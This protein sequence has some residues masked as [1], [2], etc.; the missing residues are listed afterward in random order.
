MRSKNSQKRLRRYLKSVPNH[1]SEIRLISVPILWCLALWKQSFY[2]GWGIL[3]ATLTDVLD[4]YI[5]RKYHL[6]TKWGSKL[7]SVADAVLDL[8]IFC[9]FILF[10]PEIFLNHPILCGIALLL[11]VSS[12]LYEWIRFKRFANLHLY[13]IKVAAFL[14]DAL[15]VHSFVTGGYSVWLFYPAIAVFIFAQIESIALQS[16]RSRLNEHIGSVVFEWIKIY[17]KQKRSLQDSSSF[18]LGPIS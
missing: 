17:R 6:E 2:L 3:L 5:A 13:S 7:D 9:W 11:S 10:Y 1:L 16:S 14:G 12:L 4:G 18:P 15:A 8:S